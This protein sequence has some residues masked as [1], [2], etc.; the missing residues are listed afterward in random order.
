MRLVFPIKILAKIISISAR[1]YRHSL[2]IRYNGLEFRE[3]A[4]KQ[5]PTSSYLAAVWHQDSV[6]SIFSQA[7]LDYAVMIS[8]SLD[9]E[10]IARPTEDL[11][12][13]GVR[14]SSSKGGKEAK[15][16]MVTLIKKGH[17]TAM[18]IDGPR[19]P[20]FIPK[21]GI[22]DMARQT[23][24][25]ILPASCVYSNVWVFTKSWDQFHLPKPFSKIVVTLGT[26]I[27]VPPN[28]THEEMKLIQTALRDS[29]LALKPKGEWALKN[30]WAL[31]PNKSP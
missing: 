1:M 15:D 12:Y 9:G 20:K 29:L 24:A 13:I 2:K 25:P 11:G 26:P 17:R 4:Q 3:Q 28:A 23:G 19:G 5:S 18:T 27:F 30:Q 14:G 7:Y 16:E 31:L 6:A 10:L 22:I 8:K 21:M